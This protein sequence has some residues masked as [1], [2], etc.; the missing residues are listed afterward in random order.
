MLE[1]LGEPRINPGMIY[2]SHRFSLKQRELR[3]AGDV[4]GKIMNCVEE[5]AV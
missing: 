5:G 3:N 2:N 4:S 1:D